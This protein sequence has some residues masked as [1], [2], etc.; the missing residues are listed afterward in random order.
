LGRLVHVIAESNQN[1][2]RLIRPR[3]NGGF[4]LDGLWN[5]DFHHSIHAF[6][7]G[8][9][10]GYYQ[11]FGQASQLAKTL[12][13]AFVYD[14]AYSP[15]RRRRHGSRV[16]SIDRSRFVV[17]IQ[18][19]D[20]IGNRALGDRISMLVTP[21][22]QRLACGMLLLSPYLPL[23][24]MGE[25]YGERTP[26]P[27]F[28]S[29]DDP[30]LVEAVRRGRREEFASLAFQWGTSIPDPQAP[31]TFADA[32]LDWNWPKN[33]DRSKHRLLYQ[34]LLAIRRRWSMDCNGS[35]ATAQLVCSGDHREPD[36]LVFH[37]GN[38]AELFIAANLTQEP[39]LPTGLAISER[40]LILST[41]Y[42]KY[43]GTRLPT[44]SIERMA[45][46]EVLVFE[47][48]GDES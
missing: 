15:F 26:F 38:D 34:D 5:D 21:A 30:E 42:A 24:F 47:E 44:E 45:P 19:H 7:T 23:L 35:K 4:G 29:F 37:R 36:I 16:G 18:N 11:D 20:Q 46:Y 17:S 27:F 32:K 10:D 13:D 1:D 6:L 39:V 33:T 9:R 41:E 40:R 3:K 14:G 12:N 25:E 48:P 31:E 8:E 22:A 28:C 2:V 43:G